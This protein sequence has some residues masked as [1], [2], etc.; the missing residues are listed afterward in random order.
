MSC[1]FLVV[2][3]CAGFLVSLAGGWWL[4][5]RAAERPAHTP[6]VDVVLFAGGD[7]DGAFARTIANGGRA[8]ARDLDAG[9]DVVWSSWDVQLM[10]RQFREAIERRPTGIA[11]MG[12]PGEAA[13]APLV[14]DARRAGILVTTLNVDLPG[15][16][17]RLAGQGFGYVGQDIRGS[18]RRLAEAAVRAFE[19]PAG[20]EVLL[21]GV[22]QYPIRGERTI[23]A[24]EALVQ[25]GMRVSYIQDDGHLEPFVEQMVAHLRAHPQTRLLFDDSDVAFVAGRIKQAGFPPDAFPI[26]GFDLMPET[27]ALMREGHIDLVSDQQPYLQGYLAVLQLAMSA[28]HGFSGLH[29]DTGTG[30][31]HAG[32]LEMAAEQA[33]LGVR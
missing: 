11:M 25:A 33:Q 4:G 8:A 13:L 15:V 17:A 22:K 1:R 31:I 9:L 14:D 28:R 3:V 26:V 27:V 20:S 12:H 7:A 29:I 10:A 32:N 5:R 2:L 16:E 30:F 18:G 19:I 24:E 23:A 6:R 21:T